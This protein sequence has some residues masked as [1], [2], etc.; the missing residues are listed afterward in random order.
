M[1]LNFDEKPLMIAGPCSA[2]SADQLLEMAIFLK[3]KG[4]NIMRAGVW[5]PRTRPQGFEGMGQEALEWIRE[6]KTATGISIATEVAHPVHVDL[7]LKAGI[8]ILWLGARTTVNPFLV[9]EIADSLKGTHVPV[10]VKNPVNPDVNLWMGAVERIRLSGDR[11][12]AAIHRGFSVLEPSQYRNPPLWQLAFEFRR[13]MPDIPLICDPSHITGNRT[14]VPEIAQ[15]ALDL[16]YDG[17]MI[18]V[19]PDPEYAL[20]D[21][22]QQLSKADFVKLLDSLQVRNAFSESIT[23][24]NQL[25]KLRG[26]IDRMDKELLNI[27]AERMK[28]VEQIGEYKRDNNVTVFQKER[29]SQIFSSRTDWAKILEINPTLVAQIYQLIHDES[30]RKQSEIVNQST[31]TVE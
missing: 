24:I 26:Q 2:E 4:I 1:Q 23:F 31:P 11:E 17:I 12:I 13:Q 27:I 28:L 25:E 20:S 9:Q 18:E 19:H 30:V 22:A 10:M 7:A 14:L 21:A 15:R 8:D 29:W 5:K 16:D 3:G 6:A